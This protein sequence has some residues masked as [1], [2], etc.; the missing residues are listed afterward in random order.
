VDVTHYDLGADLR[1]PSGKLRLSARVKALVRQPDVRAIPFQLGEGLPEYDSM[2]LKKQMRLKSARA[3]GAELSAAQ[4]NWEGG[5]TVFLGAPAKVGQTLE[6]EFDLEGDFLISPDTIPNCFYPVSNES[7]YPRHGYLDRATFDLSFRH[8]KNRHVASVGQRLSEE[9]APD[10]KD[11]FVTRYR[12]PHPVALIT[13]ALGPFQR[14]TQMVKWDK[15]GEPIPVEFNSLPGSYLAI[16]EDF[17]VAELDNSLRYFSL[18]FGKYPYPTFSAA[19]HPFGFGQGFPSLLMIPATDRASKYTYSFIAHET[20]HQW[21][22]DIVTWRSY[23]DQWLSEGFA[24]YSGALYTGLRQ[25]GDAR[26]DL[27]NEMRRSLKDPPVTTTGLGK[28]KLAVVG[29][30]ILGHRLS[31][32]KTYGA[33]QALIY[34]KGALVLRMLHFLLSDPASG[35]DK[36]FFAMMTDFVERHRDGFASTDDFR[37]VANEHFARTPVARKYGLK[38]LNWFFKQWVYETGLPSYKLE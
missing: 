5:L 20:A 19:F 8:R 38:D 2:R 15:G 18:L 6:L 4:E 16:K 35:D 32:S 17:I 22:G 10:D 25:S 28:G 34:N 29:P 37:V 36:A 30:I 3:G 14:H 21:W 27:I 33:Y 7:W 11:S 31:T 23:R 26:G 12:M 1:D 9:E 24:E 13:F